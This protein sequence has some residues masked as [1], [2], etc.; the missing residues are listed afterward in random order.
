MKSIQP[1]RIKTISE[2]HKV[3]GLPKPE[4]PLITVIGVIIGLSTFGIIGIVF[5]PLLFSYFVMLI[6]IYEQKY[7]A[8]TK[9][10]SE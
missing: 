3:R 10:I 6:G 1:L 8:I 2:Y 7:I 5:G 4:H 9:K